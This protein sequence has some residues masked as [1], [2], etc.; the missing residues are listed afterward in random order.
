MPAD[1]RL[2]S[3]GAPPRDERSQRIAFARGDHAA[4][5]AVVTPHLD[6]LYTLCLR[7]TRGPAVAEELAQETLVRVLQQVDRYDVD[8][9]IRP[10][11]LKVG[12][13]LCRDRLRTVWWRR[14]FSLDGLLD[15]GVAEQGVI[16]P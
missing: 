14:V 1:L 9:P 7:M 5:T 10:W 13:N 4:F 8:R 3:Q 15:G 6:A 12:L 11:L 2:V 16:A